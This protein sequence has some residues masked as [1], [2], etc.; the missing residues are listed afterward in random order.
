MM[1][2][3]IVTLNTNFSRGSVHA[4]SKHAVRTSSFSITGKERITSRR[5]GVRGKT[6]QEKE[7]ARM[8]LVFFSFFIA[9]GG[10]SCGGAS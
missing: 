2:C 8:E 10:T 9:R 1:Y 3:G 7:E 4:G 6:L 5:D